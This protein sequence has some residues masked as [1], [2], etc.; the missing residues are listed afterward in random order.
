[1]CKYPGIILLVI[2]F[3]LRN[4]GFKILDMVLTSCCMCN[5]YFEPTAMLHDATHIKHADITIII[6]CFIAM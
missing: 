5:H 3:Y 6:V 4:R 2:K 1:M